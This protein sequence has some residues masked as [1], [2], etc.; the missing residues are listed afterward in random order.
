LFACCSGFAR[1]TLAKWVLFANNTWRKPEERR[2]NQ[3]EKLVYF[4]CLNHIEIIG[5][6]AVIKAFHLVLIIGS[7]VKSKNVL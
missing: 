2:K 1:V 4:I 5:F 6:V 3:Y 7:G